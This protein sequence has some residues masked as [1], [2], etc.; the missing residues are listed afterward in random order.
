[1]VNQPQDGNKMQLYC[2]YCKKY[3]IP[4]KFKRFINI[5]KQE[6]IE[7]YCCPDCLQTIYTK[8]KKEK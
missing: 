8:N 5:K 3:V 1:M 6:Y 4:N 7:E 2:S